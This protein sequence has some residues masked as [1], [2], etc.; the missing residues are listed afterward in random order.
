MSVTPADFNFDDAPSDLTLDEIFANPEVKP[1]AVTQPQTATE[2]TPVEA[3]PLLKTAT[4]TVYKTVDDAVKGIE[5]KDALIAELRQKVLEA[6]NNDPLKKKSEQQDDPALISYIANP[7]K[8]FEDIKSAKNE[9]ELLKVQGKFVDERLAPYA[10][11]IASVVKS[12]AIEGLEQEVPEIR[13]FLHSEAYQ[14]TLDAFPL[15]KQSIQISEQY[16]E[17]SGDLAQLYRMAV[18]ASAGRNLPKSAPVSGSTTPVVARPT[19]TS[20]PATPP[21]TTRAAQPSFYTKEG[22]KAIIEEQEARGVENLRF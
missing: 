4:G 15:L 9:D 19:V 14:K 18:D 21:P 17:R 12:Q 16:P 7:K 5:H 22:R 11:I 20:T 10:P 6:T 3:E 1:T 2:V 13:K 8:Y